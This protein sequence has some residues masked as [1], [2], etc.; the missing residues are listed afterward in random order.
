MR[1]WREN[2]E[3]ERKWREIYSLHFLISLFFL[4]LNPFP[5]S[6]MVSFCPKILN[7]ALL[8]QLSKKILTY[9]QVVRAC[10]PVHPS[11]AYF[12]PV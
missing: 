11:R 8:S 4:P 1:K 12:S 7:T 10:S 9:T 3:M 6:K 5:I 2:E